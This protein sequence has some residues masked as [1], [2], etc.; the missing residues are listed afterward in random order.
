MIFSENNSSY[1]DYEFIS[2]DESVIKDIGRVIRNAAEKFM[3]SIKELI[4][5]CIA[6]I[7]NNVFTKK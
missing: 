5:K 7:E 4:L 1:L 2:I 3:G 6:L